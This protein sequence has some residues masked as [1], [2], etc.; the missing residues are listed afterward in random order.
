MFLRDGRRTKRCH[1]CTKC[2]SEVEQ[3]SSLEGCRTDSASC[4]NHSRIIVGSFWNRPSNSR[5]VS[6]ISAKFGIFFFVF[7]LTKFARCVI[8][9]VR[10]MARFAW[11]GYTSASR[12]VLSACPMSVRLVGSSAKPIKKMLTFLQ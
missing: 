11:Q 3:V 10:L 6:G 4:S 7:H 2:S 9:H 12:S 8:L 1:C 5:S